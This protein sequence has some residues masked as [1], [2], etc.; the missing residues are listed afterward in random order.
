MSTF[1]DSEKRG[2]AKIIA[3]NL[4]MSYRM[5]S[6]WFSVLEKTSLAI[7]DGE[8]FCLLGPSGCG[9]STLIN[10]LAGFTQPT[11]GEVFINGKIHS[12]PDP[13]YVMMD[14][15]Y[16]LFPWRTVIENIKFGLE[17]KHISK[18][19]QEAISRK[20]IDL[21]HLQ[22]FEDRHPFELSGGMKQRVALAR[23]LAVDPEI[24]F[25]D[26]PFNALDMVLRRELQDE[27]IRLWSKQHQ[28]VVF[29]THDIE[30]AILLGDRIAIMKN[31]P[32]QIKNIIQVNLERPRNRSDL[33]F[34]NLK[35]A[36][37]KEI[38]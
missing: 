15:E 12:R 19:D 22:G 24:I 2:T 35:E 31:R 10:V 26:E 7:Q 6:G 4:T 17:I 20:L 16:G 36:I 11:S 33:S 27:F 1:L 5:R 3:E 8:I 29:V 37:Y 38:V 18:Q 21:V 32:G 30:E 9:K 13:R 25:M 23:V 34:F 28:T 14:Q